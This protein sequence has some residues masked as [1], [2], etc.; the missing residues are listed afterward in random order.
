[1]RRYLFSA[2]VAATA[3]GVLKA[4]AENTNIDEIIEEVEAVGEPSTLSATESEI[5]LLETPRSLSIVTAEEFL[6]RHALS[7]SN[8]LFTRQPFN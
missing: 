1:M 7:L 2:S 6:E 5:P 8:P 4:N 3:I